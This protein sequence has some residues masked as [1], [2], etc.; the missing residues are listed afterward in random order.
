L[1]MECGFAVVG[2]GYLGLLI[3]LAPAENMKL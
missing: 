1:R 3:A 2:P